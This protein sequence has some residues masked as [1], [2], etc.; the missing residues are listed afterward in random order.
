MKMRI[1]C[2][3]ALLEFTFLADWFFTNRGMRYK[4]MHL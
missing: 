4:E 2:A 1:K 3:V